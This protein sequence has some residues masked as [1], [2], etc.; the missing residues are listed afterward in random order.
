MIWTWV[1]YDDDCDVGLNTS[2]TKGHIE[3]GDE[4]LRV[5]LDA[6]GDYTGEGG[7]MSFLVDRWCKF[8]QRTY[9][10]MSK[11]CPDCG[12]KLPEATR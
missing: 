1:A 7:A 9:R 4:E 5:A 6:I 11:R 2:I 12:A 3:F 10:T 8:C